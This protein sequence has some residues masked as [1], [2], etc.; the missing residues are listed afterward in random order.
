MVKCRHPLP[1]HPALGIDGQ[2]DM[3]STQIAQTSLRESFEAAGVSLEA[4]SGTFAMLDELTCK[5]A[6]GKCWPP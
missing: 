6:Q 1:A 3:E 4:L 2:I 5:E